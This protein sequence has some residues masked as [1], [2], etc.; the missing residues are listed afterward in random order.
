MNI[1]YCLFQNN[2]DALFAK[3]KSLAPTQR[4][5][6]EVKPWKS[7]RSLEA[8]KRYWALV[9][10]FGKHLGYNS[11]EMHDICRFKFLRN[12]IEIEGERIALLQTTTKLNVQDFTEYM[13]AVER[14][15]NS[16]GYFF[17]G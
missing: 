4:F 16:L 2:H 6:V 5:K 17:E 3:L 7:K 15:G 11:D 13:A 12:A 1:E 10:G 9:T 14:W 8:N